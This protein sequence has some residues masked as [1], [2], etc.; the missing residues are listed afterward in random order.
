MQ[1]YFA[2]HAQSSL[3]FFTHAEHS[4]KTFKASAFLAN[5]ECAL[6][7]ILAG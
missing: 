5:A 1:K 3:K 2:A 4:H 7:N 6:K